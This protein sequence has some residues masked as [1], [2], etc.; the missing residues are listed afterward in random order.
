MKLLFHENQTV[1]FGHVNYNRN[2]DDNYSAE[3]VDA[4]VCFMGKLVESNCSSE[5]W[6]KDQLYAALNS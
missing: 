1:M 3:E 2:S 6:F 5:F 4:N